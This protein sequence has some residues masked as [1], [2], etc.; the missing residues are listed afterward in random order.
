[1][2]TNND[3][4]LATL[5][6]FAVGIFLIP[7]LVHLHERAIHIGVTLGAFVVIG[8]I[9]VCNLVILITRTHSTRWPT[10]FTFTKFFITGVFNTTFDISVVN[11]LSFLFFAYTGW[12]LIAISTISF[13]T[14]L[15]YS[16]FINRSWSFE[17]NT[18]ANLRE[19]SNFT[20]VALGSFLIN[21]TILYILTTITGAPHGIAEALWINIIKL[22]T[23]IISMTWNF[24]AFRFFVFKKQSHL[25][26]IIEIK[27]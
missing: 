4:R 9:I 17:N 15:I 13:F 20:F 27:N 12:P 26:Q 5:L 24:I 25:E 8:V 11:L 7:P 14:I 19:F 18:K 23:A 6:A 16:Y 22:F 21:T 10:L 1:M 2:L 3:F